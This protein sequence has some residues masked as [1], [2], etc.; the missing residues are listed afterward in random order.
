MKILVMNGPNLNM[1]GVRDQHHY[2]N[3]TLAQ[4]YAMLEEIAKNEKVTVTFFQSNHEGALIDYLQENRTKLDG[5]LINPGA[6]T[7]YGYGLRDALSDTKLPIVEVHLSNILERETFRKTD[8]IEDIVV[9][10]IM[11]LKEQSYVQGLKKLIRYILKNPK[12]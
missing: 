4:I 12:S 10:R 11:G 2:G 8:V 5:I 9:E 6:L 3:I 1:L 7:H